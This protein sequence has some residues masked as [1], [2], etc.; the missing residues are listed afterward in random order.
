M[1]GNR[2]K[3]TVVWVTLVVLAII[4]VIAM[5]AETVTIEGEVNEIQQIVDSDGQVYEVAIGGQGDA[6]VENHIGETV[7]VTGTLAED[8]D[9]K[10]INVTHFEL[11]TQ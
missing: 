2:L 5:A 4:P 3:I 11:V 7:K 8:G 9:V 6:L 1:K 10:I